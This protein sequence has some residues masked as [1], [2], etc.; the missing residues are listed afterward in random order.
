MKL[1]LIGRNE[2]WVKEI[3]FCSEFYRILIVIGFDKIDSDCVCCN[4]L[5]S[6]KKNR[7]TVKSLLN[8][9]HCSMPLKTF[10]RV[11]PEYH[12]LFY[13]NMFCHL[14]KRV[15]I[16]IYFFCSSTHLIILVLFTNLVH[17]HFCLP[18]VLNDTKNEVQSKRRKN[19]KSLYSLYEYFS[20]RMF[21]FVL[22]Q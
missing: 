2:Y 9:L 20:G 16:D 8:R 12:I 14:S 18:I 11:C 22:L 21:C 7:K 4:D 5:N 6:W 17:S 1:Q 15:W 10:D 19:A 3:N 13:A